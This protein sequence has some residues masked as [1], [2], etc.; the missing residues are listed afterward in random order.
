[1]DVQRPAIP[2]YV[3]A[4][5]NLDA[6]RRRGAAHAFGAMRS[7]SNTRPPAR[8]ILIL[9]TG[10]GLAASVVVATALAS[11]PASRADVG[12]PHDGNAFADQIKRNAEA[13]RRSRVWWESY[14]QRHLNLRRSPSERAE[15]KRTE[16]PAS[17][18]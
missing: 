6:L 12:I 16:P 7:A 5:V 10:L 3:D 9:V 8:R 18:L 13:L 14:G 4:L 15:R 2:D 17:R 1:M 11:A